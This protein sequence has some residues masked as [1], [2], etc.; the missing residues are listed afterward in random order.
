MARDTWTF[1]T[2]H[3]HVLA[4]L[5]RDANMA[6]RRVAAEVGITERAVLLIL[7]D[8]EAAHV[9]TRERVGRRNRYLIHLDTPMRHPL[10][11]GAR[12]GDLVALLDVGASVTARPTNSDRSTGT[13]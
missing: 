9:I 13:R 7:A 12:V 5:H 4:C 6:L 10:L 11:G 1:L 2:N 3:A 8:L